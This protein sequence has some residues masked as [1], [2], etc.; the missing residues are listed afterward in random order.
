MYLVYDAFRYFSKRILQVLSSPYIY[1][2]I[3]LSRSYWCLFELDWSTTCA[4]T[5]T[6][7]SGT[8]H[9]TNNCPTIYL[10]LG[11]YYGIIPQYVILIKLLTTIYSVVYH[12]KTQ[13]LTQ[14][15][16]RVMGYSYSIDLNS[17]WYYVVIMRTS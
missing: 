17:T 14:R 2:F 12:V 16:T 15:C 4:V 3:V 9:T 13:Q 11:I 8:A 1:C 7:A 6:A 5:D 10:M